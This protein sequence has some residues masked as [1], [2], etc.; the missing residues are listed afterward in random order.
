MASLTSSSNG[1][2]QAISSVVV[3]TTFTPKTDTTGAL[4][5]PWKQQLALVA[6]GATEVVIDVAG[7]A[8]GIAGAGDTAAGTGSTSSS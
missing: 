5:A 1:A 3:V 4:Q 6:G 8:I 7:E 2:L